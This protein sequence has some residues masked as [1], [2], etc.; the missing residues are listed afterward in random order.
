MTHDLIRLRE[1]ARA[2]LEV[3]P[4]DDHATLWRCH[5]RVELRRG[6]WS[7]DDIL[8]GRAPKP[9]EVAEHLGNLLMTAGAT[10][11]W[12]GLVTAGLATPFNS[13]NAQIAIGDGSTAASAGQTDLQAAAGSSLGGGITGATNATPIVLTT[14]SAHGVVVGQVVVVASVGGNTN[15]NGT[16]EVSAVTS[17]TITLLNS[18][19]NAAYTSGGTVALVNKYR[20]LV[21][22]APTVTTNSVA[23]AATIAAANGNYA[24]NEWGITTGGA[25]TNKQAVAPPTLLNRAVPGTALLTKSNAA[26]AAATM[27]LS[28]A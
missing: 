23:F 28:L 15:A 10:A 17:T 22:G 14:S 7:M 3:V 8:K 25:A 6:D 20:Q 4:P 12:N 21:S 16:W 13:T 5:F 26:S 19:G 9:F 18:A 11:L 27:T 2:R 24:W 1:H